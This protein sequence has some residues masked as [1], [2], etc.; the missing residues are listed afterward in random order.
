[1]ELIKGDDDGYTAKYSDDEVE[2]INETVSSFIRDFV[3]AQPQASNMAYSFLSL[4]LKKY[5]YLDYLNEEYT[6]LFVSSLWLPIETNL[7]ADFE[8]KS[9]FHSLL[10]ELLD[11][12]VELSSDDLF[13]LTPVLSCFNWDDDKRDYLLYSFSSGFVE[14]FNFY[15]DN[16]F[17]D[18]DSFFKWKDSND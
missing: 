15:L 13:T 17:L 9:V 11:F 10:D 5:R 14:M 6:D 7:P 8:F 12:R 3:V 18:F 2:K 4:L 1:M 16:G